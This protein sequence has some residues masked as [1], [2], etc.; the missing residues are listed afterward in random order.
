[1]D[2]AEIHRELLNHQT[3]C[4]RSAR[5]WA[6]REVFWSIIDHVCKFVIFLTSGGAICLRAISNDPQSI[7]WC[8]A[9]ALASFILESFAIQGRIS[10]A[11]RQCQRY[12]TIRMLFPIDESKEDTKLLKRIRD[13]R[14][15]IENDETVVLECLDVYCHNKQCVAEDRPEDMWPMTMWQKTVGLVSPLSYKRPSA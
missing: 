4:Y 5:Y 12:N 15:K 7:G 10:F 9:S 8:T 2:S 1:M 13:E 14:L 6:C 3:D 11:V